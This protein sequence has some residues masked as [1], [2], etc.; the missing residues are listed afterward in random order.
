MAN[1]RDHLEKR[2][3]KLG[4]VIAFSY[5]RTCGEDASPC[6]KIFDC[7]WE[8]F[9]ITTYL[10]E[11]LTEHAF[12]KLADSRPKPKLASILELIEEAKKRM[13]EQNG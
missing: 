12:N 5:C 3:P 9:D 1:S 11:T 4:S 2:C 13:N 8:D 10:K 7:W 6:G